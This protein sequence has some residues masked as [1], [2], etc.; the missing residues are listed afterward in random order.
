MDPENI[1]TVLGSRDTVTPF[2]TGRA[3]I[4]E[5]RVPPENRFIW[6][7]GHFSVPLRMIRDRAPLRRLSE[8]LESLR[9][10]G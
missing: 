8:R 6:R 9:A 4:D 2:A 3:L 5:W 7:R 10:S 1:V